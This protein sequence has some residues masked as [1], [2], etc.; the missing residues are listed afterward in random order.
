MKWAHRFLLPQIYSVQRP[1]I[2]VNTSTTRDRRIA[3]YDTIASSVRCW[4]E[5]NNTSYNNSDQLGQVPVRNFT[6]HFLPEANV[7][8]GDR[9]LKDG[10]YYL[11]EG[12]IDNSK[13]GFHKVAQVTEKKYAAV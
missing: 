6:V 3:K 12:V 9:L 5:Q 10:V 13:Q 1:D 4:F 2:Q 7:T 8:E 11:V